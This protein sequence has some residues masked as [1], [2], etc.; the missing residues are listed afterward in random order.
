MKTPR[1]LF[2]RR[3]RVPRFA[4]SRQ[5]GEGFVVV[6]VIVVMLILTTLLVGNARVLHQFRREVRLI[7]QRQRAVLEGSLPSAPA[8]EVLAAP[9]GS[10]ETG[11]P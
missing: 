7:E 5:G 6:A 11:T 9:D 1:P 2:L 10:G 3:A 8:A 4:S